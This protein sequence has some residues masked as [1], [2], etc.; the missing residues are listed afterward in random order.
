MLKAFTELDFTISLKEFCVFATRTISSWARELG[1]SFRVFTSFHFMISLCGMILFSSVCQSADETKRVLSP[2]QFEL[3]STQGKLVEIF[4][5]P[6]TTLT[7]VCFLGTEC[8]LAKLYGP[9]LQQLSEMY[10]SQNIDFI[11]V[12]SNL[13]DSMEE[14]RSYAKSHG[15]TFPM[16]KDVGNKVADAYEVTR[17]PEV[18][19]VDSNF[20]IRYRGRIDDQYQP[21]MSRVKPVRQDLKEALEE[22]IAGKPVSRALTEPVGCLIGRVPPTETTTSLTYA[23]EISRILQRH[24]VEC[25]QAGEI[26]PFA[27]TD[28][29]EVVGWGEMLVEVVDQKRMP[30]W[31][32]NPSH[33]DFANARWMSEEDKEALRNWVA[34]GMP[35]GEKDNLP[36]PLK[37]QTV[38]QLGRQPDLVLDMSPKPFQVPSEGIVEYQY[39]V[40]DPGFKEDK[41]VTAAQVIPGNRSVVHHAI[42]FIRPP[43][44]SY[45]QGIGWLSGYVPG[46]KPL[47][48]QPGYA[49]LIPAGS[50]LVFQMHYT[51]TG[52]P[53][54]DTTQIGL[55]FDDEQE[56]T[57]EVFTLVGINQDFEIPPNAPDFKVHGNIEKL[58]SRGELLAMTPHMHL[59]GKSFQTSITSQGKKEILL[60]VPHYDFNWQHFYELQKPISLEE[61]DSLNFTATFD[62]SSKNPVNPAPHEYVSWGDQTW[63]E[64]AV[65]FYAVAQPRKTVSTTAKADNAESNQSKT[66]NDTEADQIVAQFFDRFDKNKDGKIY[67][68]ELPISMNSFGFNSLNRDGNEYL[69]KDEIYNLAIKQLKRRQK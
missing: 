33:G 54:T 30:P 11:G 41:W 10:A 32:A 23:K 26:G 19:V 39:F 21:G 68:E 56:I 31:H 6:G 43:D 47:T 35:F 29:D 28:Y 8:P 15:V 61:I 62:N 14:C 64:M 40:V 59:R 18:V 57:H 3:P 7:V 51:P 22:L 63:E 53:Q 49:R 52:S 38:W 60:D 34:G 46:Q 27:L 17:T 5:K 2:Y 69:S 58:P 45:F 37:P 24:C 20:E 25:H 66:K 42:V 50:K 1:T 36:P 67:R 4:R 16:L 55:L 65:V 13:H 12:N 48:M 9:R 44:G